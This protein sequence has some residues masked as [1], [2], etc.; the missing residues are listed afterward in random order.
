MLQDVFQTNMGHVVTAGFCAAFVSAM[1]ASNMSGR[2]FYSNLSDY[3]KRPGEDPFWGRRRSFGV[4]WVAG[5][6]C[7]MSALWSIRNFDQGTLPLYVFCASMFGVVAS[8]G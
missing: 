6:I 3:L 2:L 5:P 8:F 4:M 1:G 7:Y